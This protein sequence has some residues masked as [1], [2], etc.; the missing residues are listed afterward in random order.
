[1]LLSD[2]IRRPA[3][4]ARYK[5][6]VFAGM[7]YVDAPRMKFVR[8]LQNSRRTLVFLSGTGRL[9]GAEE[10]TGFKMQMIPAGR[11]G[12][13]VIPVPGEKVNMRSEMFNELIT[14]Y[15]GLKK[16]NK[17]D[18]PTRFSVVPAPGVRVRAIYRSDN[19]PAVAEKDFA[20]YRSVAVTCAGGLTPEYFHELT[21]SAG[22]F[23]VCR[24]GMQANINGNFV[25]LHCL[26]PGEYTINLPRKCT[27]VNLKSGKSQVTD[28]IKLNAVAS[29]SYWYLL[30]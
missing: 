12:H 25:S 24:P 8:S 28:T 19:A 4:A 2:I 23:T 16:H 3:D 21:A 27:A 29:S 17:Y 18:L 14:R 26:I 30:K 9:G 22:G 13:E 6:I 11:I 10:A 15:L 20:A 1:V 7:N 5:V